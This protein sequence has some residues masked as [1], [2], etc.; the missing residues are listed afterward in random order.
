VKTVAV[1]NGWKG[2]RAHA[3]CRKQVIR[4]VKDAVPRDYRVNASLC[5]CKVMQFAKKNTICSPS[6]TRAEKQLRM[7]RGKRRG[8]AGKHGSRTPPR[9]AALMEKAPPPSAAITPSIPNGGNISST[10][11]SKDTHRDYCTLTLISVAGIA[12]IWPSG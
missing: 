10:M 4:K 7:W 2:S 5:F 1:L 8:T 11:T 3:V 12:C 9:G 6:T